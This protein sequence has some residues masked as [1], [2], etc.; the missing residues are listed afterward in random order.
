MIGLILNKPRYRAPLVTTAMLAAAA[1]LWTQ[2][3]V[4]PGESPSALQSPQAMGVALKAEVTILEDTL[5]R[6]RTIQALNSKAADRGASVAF[7]V[8]E[9][10]VVG[11]SL[12]IPRQAI[13]GGETP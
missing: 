1:H 4:V 5:I 6:V 10:V 7:M 8:S 11:G 2:A 3:V 13:V 12:A 9:E